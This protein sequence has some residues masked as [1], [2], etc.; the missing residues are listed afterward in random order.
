MRS[1]ISVNLRGFGWVKRTMSMILWRL[2]QRAIGRFFSV[3]KWWIAAISA[4][5]RSGKLSMH[6]VTWMIPVAVLP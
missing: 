4:M 1:M 2:T 3:V 6:I 5:N